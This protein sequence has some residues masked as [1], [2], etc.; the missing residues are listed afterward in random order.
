MS[1]TLFQPVLP[2]VVE[3]LYRGIASIPSPDSIIFMSSKERESQ[4]LLFDPYLYTVITVLY[5]KACPN[6][7]EFSESD[8]VFSLCLCVSVGA[9]R[10][11]CYIVLDVMLDMAE[12]EGVVDIYNCVKTLCSRRINMIQTEVNGLAYSTFQWGKIK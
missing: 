3:A 8:M 11:G 10:T 7:S 4:E 2:A 1:R 5:V 9:G 12:C 6:G